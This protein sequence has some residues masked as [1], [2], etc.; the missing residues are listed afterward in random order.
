MS[1]AEQT[2]ANDIDTTTVSVTRTIKLPLQTSERKNRIVQAGIDAYQ[3][4]LEFMADRLPTYPE[5]EWEPHHSHMYH[6][7]KRGLPELP[8]D[9]EGRGFKTTLAQQA[10]QQVAEA[11]KS[12]RQRGKSENN[13]KGDFGGASYL[14]LRQDDCEIVKNNSGYGLKTSFVSYNPLWF[15][16][17]VGEYQSEFLQH[18]VDEND[19]AT[20]GSLELHLHDD[21]SLVAHQTVSWDVDTLKR[22]DVGTVVGVDLND[23]PLACAAVWS[24]RETAVKDVDFVS[25]SEFRHYRERMKEAKDKAMA[26]GNLKLIKDARRNYEKYTDHMTNVASRRVVETAEEHTPCR[27]HLENLTHLR[28]TVDDPIH[29]WPYAMIQEQI[30]SKAEE[31][32]VPVVMVNPRD[33]SIECRKCG[34]VNAANR[35]SRDFQCIDCGYEVH[36]DVNAAINIAKRAGKN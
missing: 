22:K 2:P 31:I 1:K 8:D 25:G 6:Q 21:G 12:W 14:Q 30:I 20:A 9:I 24:E 27:I 28:E 32:G 11:F 10:Q 23:D 18:V 35:S 33:T 26:D 3:Q 13:P 29:D 34:T 7:A 17:T 36:A 5:Q 19:S 15:G 16:V 4:V